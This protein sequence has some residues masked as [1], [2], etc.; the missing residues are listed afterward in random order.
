ML[1]HVRRHAAARISHGRRDVPPGL[2]PGRAC[3]LAVDVALG[4][5]PLRRDDSTSSLAVGRGSQP[6]QGSE[7]LAV[8]L[9]T[10]GDSNAAVAF[11]G[12]FASRVSPRRPTDVFCQSG[13]HGVRELKETPGGPENPSSAVET[14]GI[15]FRERGEWSLPQSD[16]RH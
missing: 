2:E 8:S 3:T 15:G 10:S 13:L 11:N 6:W 16:D 12:P 14:G 5:A 4:H 9:A 7:A 1:P